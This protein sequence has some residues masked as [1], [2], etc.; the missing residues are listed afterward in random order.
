MKKIALIFSVCGI[1]SCGH[2]ESRKTSNEATKGTAPVGESQIVTAL[3]EQEVNIE[4]KAGDDMLFNVQ[5]IK[6]QAGQNITLIFSHIGKSHKNTMGHNFVLLQSGVDPA[7]FA[8]TASQFQE[9]DFIPVDTSQI[10]VHT[11]LLS[12]GE[13]DTLHFQ[14][15]AKGYYPFLC[16]FPGHVASMK[17]KFI[18]D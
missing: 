10:I 2:S 1:L 17:G 5:E 6:V 18:V 15:P 16:S 3:G 7:Q 8:K 11:K 12:G 14:A 13:S 9:R 4:L